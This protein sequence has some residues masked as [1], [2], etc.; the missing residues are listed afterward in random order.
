[1]ARIIVFGGHGKVALQLA[2]DLTQRGDQVS[3]VFRNPD[4]SDDVAA[5]GAKPV[6]A[7]IER[8]DTNALADLQAGHDAVVF[9]AGAGGGD[10]DRTYAVDRDAA[11]RV[12]DAAGKAGVKR[13]VMVSYFGAGPDHGVSQDDPFFAYAEAKAAADAHLRDSE[14]DWTILGP[15]RLTLDPATGKIVL[16]RGDGEVSRADVALVAAAA[17][18]DDSTIRRTIE[19]NNGDIPI[20]QALAG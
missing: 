4:H 6:V 14:L 13:F 12:I 2:R 18:A 8:L 7:D 15:G 20:A 3:S 16:G 19:F 17:L 1:M 11:I 5:T 10:P 9:S